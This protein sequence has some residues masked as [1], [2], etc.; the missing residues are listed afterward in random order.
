MTKTGTLSEIRLCDSSSWN[1]TAFVTLDTDWAHD[2][3]LNFAA[4]LLEQHAARATWF[5]THETDF[6]ERLRSNPDFEI[7]IHPNFNELLE[8]NV[9]SG[10][11]R[12]VHNIIDEMMQIVPEAKCIRSHSLTHSSRM[13]RAY[14]EAGLECESNSFIPYSTSRIEL[15]PWEVCPGITSVPFGWGDYHAINRIESGSPVE[16]ET[17]LKLARSDSLRVFNVHPIHLFLN[18]GRLQDYESTRHLHHRPASLA[19]RRNVD[20]V[21]VADLISALLVD[22]GC[23]HLTD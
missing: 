11:G 1:Q 5:V 4:D 17:P 20:T 16:S 10:K 2:S 8:G 18:S 9:T 22:L 21:G 12:N 6:L 14:L 19:K 3:V 15:R 7:G 23:S 13:A